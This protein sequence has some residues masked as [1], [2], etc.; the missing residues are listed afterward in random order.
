MKTPGIFGNDIVTVFFCKGYKSKL[1]IYLCSKG[2][3]EIFKG[4]KILY[5]TSVGTGLYLI[6]HI[7]AVMKGKLQCFQQIQ[8]AVWSPHTPSLQNIFTTA[9]RNI[10][11]GIVQIYLKGFLDS[12]NI[13]IVTVQDRKGA[14][15]GIYLKGFVKNSLVHT[16]VAS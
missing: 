1:R 5:S 9:G 2:I 13:G 16:L 11:H 7:S 4:C 8:G 15:F 3:P 6:I 14:A 12:G 10:A